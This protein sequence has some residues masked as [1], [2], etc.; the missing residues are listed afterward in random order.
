MQQ[1]GTYREI[2]RKDFIRYGLCSMGHRLRF[3][4]ALRAARF[5][6]CSLIRAYYS[7]KCKIFT[8]LYGLE[9]SPD[10]EIG[11][12]FRL[13]HAYDITINPNAVIGRNCTMHRG[14]LIGCEPRGRRKGSPVIGNKVWIG[15]NAVIVGNVHIGDDVVIAANSFVNCDVPSHSIV[16]GNPCTIHHKENATEGYI[17][18]PV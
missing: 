11:E 10:T 5:S 8:A 1:F 18:Y 17:V 14:I 12:G 15:A 13:D 6:R 2:F 3:L 9:I 7:F 4:Y 16:V